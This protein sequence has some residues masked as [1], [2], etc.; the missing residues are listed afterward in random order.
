LIKRITLLNL[1]LIAVLSLL[2]HPA[3]SENSDRGILFDRV[4]ATVNED[5]ITWSELRRIIELEGGESLKGKTGEEREKEIK[6]LEKSFLNDLIDMKLQLQEARRIG[7]DVSESEVDEAISE[8]KRK[9]SLTD[10]ALLNSLKAEGFTLEEYRARLAEQILLSKVV[11]FEV[12]NNIVISD[13]EIDE[14]YEANEEKYHER[15]KVR[16]RQI[17]FAAS[18]D[19]S[20]RAVIEAKVEEIIKRLQKGED[21]AKLASKFSEDPSREFGGDLGYVSHGSILKEIED[22]AFGLKKGEISKPFWSSKGLHIIKLEDRIEAKEIEE[23]REEI[24]GILF[25][26][27]FKL[28]YDEWIK[29]LREKAYIEIKL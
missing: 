5:V 10:E 26:K 9:Y 20:Q 7:L 12:R 16:I 21:F 13:K 23:V 2:S 24:R 6:K 25:K 28:K 3:I 19:E 27:A 8:I 22:V 11:N 15:G 17:F 4:V 29:E 14:Y 18:G 1:A